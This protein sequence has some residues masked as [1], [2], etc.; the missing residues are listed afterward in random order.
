MLQKTQ[1]AAVAIGVGLMLMLITSNVGAQS[2]TNNHMPGVDFSKFHTYKWVKVEGAEYPNQIEDQ[3]IKDAVNTQ[4]SAKG[5][6][7]SESDNADLHIAYQTALQQQKQWNAYG[8]GGRWG[9]GM[10]SAQSSTIDIGTIVLDMYDPTTKQ[11]VWT[12][13]A[14]KTLD[15]SQNSEKNQKNLDKAMAKLLKDYPPKS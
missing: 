2:V 11:L 15:P 14:T 8:M 5:L 7:V 12:G 9:G 1:K 13:R 6:T 3:Q 10:A 4:L